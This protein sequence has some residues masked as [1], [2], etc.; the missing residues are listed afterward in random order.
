MN[1]PFSEV[2]ADVLIPRKAFSRS[3]LIF[4]ASC[5]E[6]IK[7]SA[8]LVWNVSTGGNDVNFIVFYED[9]IAPISKNTSVASLSALSKSGG[10]DNENEMGDQMELSNANVQ[11]KQLDLPSLTNTENLETEDTSAK[12]T[13]DMYSSNEAKT[14]SPS[15][16]AKLN[17][18]NDSKSNDAKE[19]KLN[20]AK[21]SKKDGST[22]AFLMGRATQILGKAKEAYQE[23]KT[24]V[25]ETNTKNLAFR[26]RA[27]AVATTLNSVVRN[28]SIKS[29]ASLDNE[30]W[31]MKFLP[32]QP[33]AMIVVPMTKINSK[34]G[35]ISGSLDITKKYGVYTVVFDNSMSIVSARNV[36]VSVQI[37]GST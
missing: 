37:V 6:F 19:S 23:V 24:V 21:D 8:Q 14:V 9:E 36:S 33:R 11:E 29:M 13:A 22:R 18:V 26:D 2:Y 5:Q 35:M 3:T 1:D 7:T 20:E 34:N 10:N 16:G 32:M 17:D 30:D 25:K 4:S 31:N 12:S 15:K 28:D 27:A